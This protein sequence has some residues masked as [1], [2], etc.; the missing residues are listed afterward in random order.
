MYCKSLKTSCALIIAFGLALFMVGCSQPQELTPE[1]EAQLQERATERWQLIIAKDY[2]GA[3]ELMTPNYRRIFPKH[4]YSKNFSEMLERELTEVEVLTYDADAAVAS[5]A[6]RVMSKPTK[7]SSAA[8]IAFG[9]MTSSA[10]EQWILIDGKWWFS[11][12]A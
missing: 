8:S 4:L 11:A 10:I 9:A 7:F 1:L 12:E 2:E 6:V 5:V 3:W